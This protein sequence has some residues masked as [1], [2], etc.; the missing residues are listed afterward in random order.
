MQLPES[1]TVATI[2]AF[3]RDTDQALAKADRWILDGSAVDTLDYAGLQALLACLEAGRARGLET[4][5]DKPSE[6]L[7]LH[8][9]RT[10][11]D[12]LAKP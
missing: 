4:R 10:G 12:E 3:Y 6:N 2:E 7:R 8:L 9:E 1:L 11:L 5:L